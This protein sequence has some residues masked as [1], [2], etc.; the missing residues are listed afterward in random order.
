[1]SA[2]TDL[3]GELAAGV[4]VPLAPADQGGI[5]RAWRVKETDTHYIDVVEQLFNWRVCSTAKPDDGV[6]YDAAYCYIGKGPQ[7]FLAAVLGAH[8][9]TG[10]GDGA[11]PGWDKN[12]FTG[13]WR[14]DSPHAPTFR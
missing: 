14:A 6:C 12:P 10:P 1:V 11:P 5:A 7:S 9:W 4:G 13:E 2:A 8:A 3:F